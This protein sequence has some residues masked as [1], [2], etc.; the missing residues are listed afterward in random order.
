MSIPSN[1]VPT[2]ITQLPEDPAPSNLGWMMYVNNGVTYKVQ[3]NAVLNATGVPS[4]RTITAGAGLTG[5]GDLSANRTFGVA[6]GGIGSTQLDNTGVTPGVYGSST[7]LPILTVDANGRVTAATTTSFS[8][9]GFVPDTRQ[10]IAGTGLSGGGALNA[11]VTLNA[12]FSSATPLA[13]GAATAGTADI[14]ARQ[15]HVHP[16]VD[17]ASTVVTTGV[18]GMVSG[19]TGVAHTAPAAG[20]IAYSDGSGIQL[21]TVGLS[22]QVLVSLGA[23]A[24]T[25]ATVEVVSPQAANTVRAGPISGAAADPTYRAL[26]N[27]DLPNTG[28]SANTYGTQVNVPVF[29]VNAKGVISSVTNTAIGNLPNSALV[30]SAITING[31]STALGG[32]ISVGTVTSVAALTLGTT[33]TDLTST[34]ATGTTTPVITLNVP[35]ASAANRGALTAADWSTFNDKQPAFT[36]QTANYVYAAPNGSAGVPSFRALLA[37]DL[38]SLTS[39]YIPYTG[40]TTDVDLNAKHLVNVARLSVG[41]SVVPTILARVVGDN[42]SLSRIAMRGYSSDANSSAIRV[43]KF[44]GNAGA[45]QVPISGDSLGKFE[46]AGYGSTAAE[47]YPQATIEGVTTELWSAVARGTKALI[48]V[49]PNTTINQVTAV[50]IDQDLRVTAAG[51]LTVTGHTTFEGVTST[52]ATGTGNLVYSTSP[53]LTT[54]LLGVVTSGDFSTGIFSWP[55]FNQNTSGSAATLTTARNIAGVSF[56]GSANINIPLANLSDVLFV[57][58]VVDEILKYNGAVWV[59]GTASSISAG[60]GVE[61]YNATP[62]ITAA[63]TNNAI[64]IFTL[65][66][67]PITTAEQ[68]T[69]TTTINGTTV[70]TSWVS[71]ALGRTTIDAG[72]WDFTVFASVSSISGVNT[73]L[74][75]QMYAALPFVTGTVTT[76]GTGTSRTATAS[77]GTPFAVTKIDASATNTLASYLQTPQG[78]YQITARTSDTVVTITTLSTYANESAVAG[79]VWKLLFSSGTTP[80]LTTSITQYDVIT[81]QPAFAT[82]TATKLGAITFVTSTGVR[83]VTTTFNGTARNTHIASPLAILHNQI[84][85]LQGGVADE[86]YHSTLA[87]YTGSGTGVFARVAGPILTT[88]TLGVASATSVAITGT[89][90]AGYQ[91]FVGQSVNPAAPAAG[92]LLIHSATANGYTRLQQDN[93]SLTN[94]ILGRDN[95]FIGNNATG[96]TIAKGAAVYVTG[97]TA[98]APTVALAQANSGTTLPCVG[99]AIDAIAP[100]AFGPIMYNGLLTFDTS[101]FASSDKV[102][103]STTA[104]GALQNTRASGTTNFVQRMGTILVSGN[105]TTGLMFVHCAPAVQNQETGTNAATWTGT[106]ISLGGTLVA[107]GG[108]DKLT[109]ATG[110]VS[111]AAATAPTAGQILTATGAATATWQGI[112][113]GTF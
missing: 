89:A 101:A 50:T 104:A 26:V 59:N 61:Y 85:G 31:T 49:T 95:V 28:V 74:S 102:W 105:S 6:V 15:G 108:V 52:G 107:T 22:G 81:V 57:T 2:S 32:S 62:Q 83:T 103:V 90:G 19:G 48:K 9:S 29:A 84:G 78:L 106:N 111:V 3:V 88:P 14:A 23:S 87:E 66:A 1:L 8:V 68:T 65:S 5:G 55:T 51:A 97:A 80:N 71:T 79:T 99:L 12:V 75:R 98:G 60:F 109:N 96:S 25:W 44:R 18:L 21:S 10:V 34:V 27:N 56:N 86:Y 58:P 20:S 24:P 33:G 112:S 94:I 35:T 54:P 73:T 63:G 41:Q 46:L 113:G 69:T 38:P 77:A 4:T 110:T 92:T 64:A 37:A 7:A 13:L 40:A 36:S 30:N 42:G 53:T 43:A 39:V 76:T 93:E 16:A 47:S 70:S 72:S 82:T 67:T 91:T 100:G 11:N 17:L 45:P